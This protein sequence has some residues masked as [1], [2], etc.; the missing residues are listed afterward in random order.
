MAAELNAPGSWNDGRIARR[1]YQQLRE[2]T[3]EGYYLVCDTAFSENDNDVHSGIKTPLKDGDRVPED[4]VLQEQV[5]KF[6]RALLSYRQTAEWGMRQVQGAF[7]RLR[8]PLNVNEPRK[9]GC[10]LEIIMRLNNI[11]ARLLGINQIR[12]VYMP[13]WEEDDGPIMWNSL[14]DML[15]RDIRTYDRVSRFHVTIRQ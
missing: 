10:R 9:C 4:P 15:I 5:M 3:P 12:N 13:I 7:G 14:G 2:S 6:N 8:L 1:I 11:R